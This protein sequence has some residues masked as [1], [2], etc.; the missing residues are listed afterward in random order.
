[1]GTLGGAEF[2]QTGL[3]LFFLESAFRNQSEADT[4]LPFLENLTEAEMEKKTNISVS[5]FLIYNKFPM[6]L[7]KS[8]SSSLSDA[9][10]EKKIRHFR[11]FVF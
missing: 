6:F 5:V 10:M 8:Q 4:W 1:M 3:N 9:E 7:V 11:L 2:V